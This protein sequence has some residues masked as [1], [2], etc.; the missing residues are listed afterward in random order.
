[1]NHTTTR[2]AGLAAA[3]T[4]IAALVIAPLHA[5]ARF[6]TGAGAA[7]DDS[8]LVA[9]WA[10]PA[11]D[12]AGGLLTFASPDLVY[13]TYGKFWLIAL[14]A[15]TACAYAFRSRRVGVRTGERWAWRLALTGYTLMAAGSLVSYWTAFVDVGFAV[16]TLPGLLITLVG[17]TALGVA[18]LRARVRPSLTA[19]LLA[20][21]IPLLVGFSSIGS[22][23]TGAL[24]LVAAWGIAGWRLWR[25]V[26]AGS[27]A[28]APQ[29]IRT[30]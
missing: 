18:L 29:Q 9:A 17:S 3:V 19:W 22:F 7:D 1:M 6:G 16:F 21:Q 26:P 14:A 27:A 5:L 25:G 13:L 30:A 2:W 12:A 24:P 4:A 15:I 28:T 11:R 20:L 10:E 8:P 23:S